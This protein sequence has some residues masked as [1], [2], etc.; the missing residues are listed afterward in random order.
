MLDD[1]AGKK[2]IWFDCVF[3]GIFSDRKRDECIDWAPEIQVLRAHTL[4]ILA[5]LLQQTHKADEFCYI[6]NFGQY[7]GSCCNLLARWQQQQEQ[8]QKWDKWNWY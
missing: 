3:F 4:R 5:M 8:Q 2:H 7:H 1:L 6:Y